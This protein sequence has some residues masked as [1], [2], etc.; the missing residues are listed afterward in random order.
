VIETG[1]ITMQDSGRTLLNN[2]GIRRAYL[3]EGA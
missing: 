1:I 2:E 3:G